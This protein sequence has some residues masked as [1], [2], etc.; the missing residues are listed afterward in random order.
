MQR[1]KTQSNI[2]NTLLSFESSTFL[3]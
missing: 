2:Q 3:W 1:K